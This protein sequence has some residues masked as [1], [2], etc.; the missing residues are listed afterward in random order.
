MLPHGYGKLE[1]LISGDHGFYDFLG[2][3]ELPSLVLT[4]FAELFCSLL[5]ILG[6]FTRLASIPLLVTMAVA[7]FLVHAGDPMDEKE[8]ALIY[9]GCYLA[10]ALIGPGSYSVDK[11]IRR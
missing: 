10:I 5:V 4:V 9:L 11:L 1:R 2:I 8:M 3:G 7:A 6:L